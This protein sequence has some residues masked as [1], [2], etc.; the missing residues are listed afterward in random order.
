M[1]ALGVVLAVMLLAVSVFFASGGCA[2]FGG[3]PRGER[4]ERMK[5]S[6]NYHNRRF[7]NIYRIQKFRVGRALKSFLNGSS[8]KTPRKALP[9]QR[10]NRADY[11]QAPASGL[12]VTWLGHSTLLV[13]VD[14]HR[15]LTDPVWSNRAGPG[16]GLGPKR[17]FAPPLPLEQLPRLDAVIISHDHYDHLDMNTIRRLNKLGVKFVVP[18]GVGAHLERWKV[19]ASRIVELDWW[20]SHTVGKLKLVATPARHGSG[21]SLTDR[22]ATLWASWSMVGPKHRVFF[23][24]DGGYS[25]SFAEIGKKYGPFDVTLMESGAY[26]TAWSDFHLG[27]E[28]SVK[29]HSDL[30]GKVMIPI[31]WGTFVLAP[32]GWTE[33]AERLRVAARN[34]GATLAIPRPGDQV[35]PASP[36]ALT[37][38]WPENPWLTAKQ[39]PVVASQP[40][41]YGLLR[42][43]AHLRRIAQR[44]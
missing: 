8:Y 3:T 19:P 34:A 5:R 28:Q 4:L 13:E 9:V 1:R 35:E 27:P 41:G 40:A 29:A 11:A 17:F 26:N 39:S 14:G 37:R 16:L 25:P 33:P 18:L 31:H 6:P 20:Q 22:N 32:H 15:I 43:S 24:G 2:A 7:V 36:P 42:R 38:W 30:R 12:R 10:R 44:P 21:R 23:S